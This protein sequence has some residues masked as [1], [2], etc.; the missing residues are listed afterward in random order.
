MPRSG[1]RQRA[2][3]VDAFAQDTREQTTGSSGATTGPKKPKVCLLG[4]IGTSTNHRQRKEGEVLGYD[5]DVRGDRFGERRARASAL[6][7]AYVAGSARWLS[8]VIERDLGARYFGFDFW[9]TAA[10]G[11][12]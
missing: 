10:W 9:S 4:E 3:R 5:Q 2:R 6:P 8:N 7:Q 11:Q 12:D 1:P